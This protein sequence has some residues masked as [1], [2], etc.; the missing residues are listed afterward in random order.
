MLFLDIILYKLS[1]LIWPPSKPKQ[2]SDSSRNMG[3]EDNANWIILEDLERDRNIQDSQNSNDPYF[4]QEYD[5]G[6]GW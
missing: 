4:S 1:C 2:Y 5:D 3:S 6:P